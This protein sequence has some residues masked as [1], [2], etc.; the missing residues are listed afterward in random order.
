[1][2]F[3]SSERIEVEQA[4]EKARPEEEGGPTYLI[5]KF[6]KG[7]LA[8]GAYEL[9]LG[10]YHCL[11]SFD[12]GG[13][14][15]TVEKDAKDPNISIPPG[16]FAL[17]LT[18]EKVRVPARAIGLISMKASYKFQGLINVSGF[19]VD[20]GWDNQLMF[21]VYNTGAQTIDL[22]VGSPLFLVWYADLD[23]PGDGDTRD[24]HSRKR[25]LISSQDQR[26]L[27]GMVGSAAAV[28]AEFRKHSASIKESL[29]G[30][31][32]RLG[33]VE[34]KL[35]GVES[36]VKWLKWMGMAIFAVVVISGLFDQDWGCSGG[37]NDAAGSVSPPPIEQPVPSTPDQNTV[38]QKS[39]P[40]TTDGP[41]PTE[42]PG[43]KP[44]T[45]EAPEAGSTQ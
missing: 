40:G 3:W 39:Q 19:H 26:N 30:F 16:Q 42:V 8:H 41:A 5:D 23:Y 15:R 17:L 12:D 21:S 31:G 1:M 37:K 28:A 45:A 20:P 38:P 25:E 22:K 43:A 35:G 36:D 32:N 10:S 14:A 18:E 11:S 2:S 13:G 44:S 34:Q 33:A 27:R 6:D 29:E 4:K 7:R 9:A 24:L